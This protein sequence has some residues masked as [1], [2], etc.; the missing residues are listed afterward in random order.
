M[1]VLRNRDPGNP[2][3]EFLQMILDYKEQLEFNPLVDGDPM[4]N[5]QITVCIRSPIIISF[6]YILMFTICTMSTLKEWE[7]K[8]D[9]LRAKLRLTP[10]GNGRWVKR[11]WKEKIPTLWRWLPMLYFL[12][13]R[14]LQ[15]QFTFNA[16]K[17]MIWYGRRFRRN[18]MIWCEIYGRF[19]RKTK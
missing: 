4:S 5:H 7:R 6:W 1:Q 19:H 9:S 3:W 15:K 12:I 18:I 13:D 16:W 17:R 8:S 2:N 14:I 10:S 11:S